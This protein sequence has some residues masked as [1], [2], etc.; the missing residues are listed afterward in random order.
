MRHP[1]LRPPTVD[2]AAAWF[3]FL[4]DQQALTYAGIVPGDFAARQH[5]SRASWVEGLAA[6]FAS[7]GS[8]R[9]IVA[10]VGGALV[11]IA[12]IVDGPADWE[13]SQGYVPSPAARELSRLYVARDFHGTGLAGALFDAIDD[14]RDLYLWLIDG[15]ERGRRFYLRRG[16]VDLPERFEAGESWGNVGMHRMARIAPA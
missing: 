13:I 10:E 2:D 15:N 3:D 12:S 9:R 4:V 5:R 8:A 7:P 16:F 6:K 1:S 11:G 14:G